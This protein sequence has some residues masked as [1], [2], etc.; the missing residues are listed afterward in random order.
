MECSKG[1][2]SS[3]FVLKD[4]LYPYVGLQG[5]DIMSHVVQTSF[6]KCIT[7][8]TY[9]PIHYIE[10]DTSPDRLACRFLISLNLFYTAAV[11]SIMNTYFIEK[12]ID[13]GQLILLLNKNLDRKI[14]L[15]KES[16]SKALGTI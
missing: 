1:S 16:A 13:T 3:D 12:P 6:I 7:K 5:C 8:L 11:K 4:M 2:W 14:N 15:K 10:I 9:I